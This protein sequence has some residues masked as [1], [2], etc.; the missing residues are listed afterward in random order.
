MDHLWQSLVSWGPKVDI[1]SYDGSHRDTIK[2][3]VEYLK[4]LVVPSSAMKDT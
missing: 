1:V 4:N 3:K 2:D